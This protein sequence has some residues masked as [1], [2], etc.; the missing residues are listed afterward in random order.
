MIDGRP[1]AALIGAYIEKL[2]E[3]NEPEEFEKLIFW[4]EASAR[5]VRKE[6][7]KCSSSTS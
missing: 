3:E 6:K 4:L 5:I 1:F 7:S 2:K